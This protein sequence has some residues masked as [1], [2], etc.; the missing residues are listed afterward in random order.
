LEG[1]EEGEKRGLYEETSP[2]IEK[3]S[4]TKKKVRKKK[5][6]IARLFITKGGE[7]KTARC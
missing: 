2:L 7:K 5:R 3:K 1:Q 6:E 4:Q